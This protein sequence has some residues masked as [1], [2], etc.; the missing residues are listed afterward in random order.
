MRLDLA[1]LPD[2]CARIAIA[3]A[4]DGERTFGDLWAVSVSVDGEDG[5][6]ATFVLDAGTNERTMVRT[7]IYRWAGKWLLSTGRDTRSTPGVVWSP[8]TGSTITR[9]IADLCPRFCARAYHVRLTSP[10]DYTSTNVPP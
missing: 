10:K 7:E 8:D 1:A 2:K 9:R 6:V 3:A 5:T 4:I